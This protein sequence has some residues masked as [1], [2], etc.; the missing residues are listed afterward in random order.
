ME[1]A[2]EREQ[3]GERREE[4]YERNRETDKQAN[5]DGVRQASRT[6]AACIIHRATQ[7]HVFL[8]AFSAVV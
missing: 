2:S 5:K 7:R 1:R 8:H 3:S 6:H 4:D